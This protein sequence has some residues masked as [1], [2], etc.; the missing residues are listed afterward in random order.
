MLAVPLLLTILA[1]LIGCYPPHPPYQPLADWN[2]SPR[3]AY[4]PYQPLLT[5]EFS[6]RQGYVDYQIDANTFLI[7]YSNYWTAHLDAYFF[8]DQVSNK[9]Q[10][11]W[12]K[13]AQE[14]VLYRA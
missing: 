12:L 14:Y 9:L 4:P 8:E 1:A 2:F 3:Q 5:T 13:G 6:P 11:K 7:T 10:D